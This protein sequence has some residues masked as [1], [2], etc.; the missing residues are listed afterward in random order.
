MNQFKKSI[1]R[2]PILNEVGRAVLRISG[3]NVFSDSKSYWEKRYATGGTSGNGSYGAL[4]KFKAETLNT[5]VSSNNI[6]SVIEFGCG[7]GNQLLL[8]EYPSYVGL[9]VS[10]KAVELCQAQFDGDDTKQFFHYAPGK[11]GFQTFPYEA[12]LSLSLDVIYHLVE[13][14]VFNL[15]MTQLFMAATKFVI[16]Y[17]SNHAANNDSRPSH[18]RH[19]IF[20]NWIKDNEPKWKQIDMIP[21]KFP[22]DGTDGNTSFADFY[23]FKRI[24]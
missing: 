13:D 18:I 22:G 17:S 8:S 19:R 6:R 3:K 24:Q 15:Y 21:N 11:I 7:D 14:D 16:I 2:I 20:T 5:F 10:N 4:A 12:E 1:K 9:D 23:F